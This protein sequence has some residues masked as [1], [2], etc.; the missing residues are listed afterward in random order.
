MKKPEP[1]E[2]STGDDDHDLDLDETSHSLDDLLPPSKLYGGNAGNIDADLDAL[3]EIDIEDVQLLKKK[4]K[5]RVKLS[6]IKRVC[7]CVKIGKTT[8]LHRNIYRNTKLCIVGPHWAGIVFTVGLLYS[9]SYY[10]TTKAYHELGVISTA[11]CVGF[12]ICATIS[13]FL[14]SCRD[15]GIVRDTTIDGD[16]KGEYGNVMS[17]GEEEGWRWCAVCSVHQPPTAAHCVDCGVCVDGYDHHCPWMGIC[18]GKGNFK[19]FMAFN[20]TWLGYLIYASAWVSALGPQMVG[21]KN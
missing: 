13:L 14:V 21:K 9:A 15:P 12:T 5:H 3:L 10:F 4:E 1:L 18:I 17:N 8:V 20:L 11:I 7:G 19:A 16:G 2:I 6:K